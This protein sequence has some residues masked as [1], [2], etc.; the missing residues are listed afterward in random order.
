MKISKLPSDAGTVVFTIEG[1]TTEKL[2]DA[3]HHEQEKARLFAHPFD[4]RYNCSSY[5]MRYTYPNGRV[6]DT[7]DDELSTS[8]RIMR[9]DYTITILLVNFALTLTSYPDTDALLAQM[10]EN[11]KRVPLTREMSD[12]MKDQMNLRYLYAPTKIEVI[13]KLKQTLGEA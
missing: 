11:G 7:G 10:K 8:D 9:L 5:R 6:S 13:F 3:W 2:F 1:I 12:D 4:E